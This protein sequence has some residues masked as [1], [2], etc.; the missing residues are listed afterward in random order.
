MITHQGPNISRPGSREKAVADMSAI[1]KGE[2]I[3]GEEFMT[4]DLD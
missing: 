2:I 3:F 1:F 4:L